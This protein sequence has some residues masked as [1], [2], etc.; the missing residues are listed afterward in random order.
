MTS[1][2]TIRSACI[3]L[4]LVPVFGGCASS[5]PLESAVE[6]ADPTAEVPS[7]P[8]AEPARQAASGTPGPD[9]A[10]GVRVPFPPAQ[11]LVEWDI[12]QLDDPDDLIREALTDPSAK[13]LLSNAEVGGHFPGQ[14]NLTWAEKRTDPLVESLCQVGEAARAA[15][16][17]GIGAIYANDRDAG[18]Y[19]DLR[20]GSDVM[21]V[22]EMLLA[23]EDC[24]DELGSVAESFVDDLLD[25][26]RRVAS[27]WTSTDAAD[28]YHAV[29]VGLARGDLLVYVSLETPTA[30]ED[31]GQTIEVLTRTATA[32]LDRLDD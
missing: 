8:T 15:D 4:L 3:W 9:E 2:R 16:S 31:V 7:T 6:P 23:S 11:N 10:V 32:M 24:S 22:L 26:D 28:A 30:V 20:R 5:E 12:V 13:G 1:C 25:G 14:W 18:L 17:H 19:V 29:N 27:V 21:A